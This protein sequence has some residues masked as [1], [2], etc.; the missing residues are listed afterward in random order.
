[1]Q[2]AADKTAVKTARPSPLTGKSLPVGNHPGNTGGKK[3][4]SG[5]KP[6]AFTKLL[7]RLRQ[8]P[9]LA[10]SLTKAISDPECRAFPSA[11]KVLT[12]YDTEK[13]VEKKELT[14]ELVVRV[15]RDP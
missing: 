13:P 10:D 8:S 15:V 7:A 11:L 6:E 9:E 5:R 14:G 3:G 4:R 1:M 2:S 12:D